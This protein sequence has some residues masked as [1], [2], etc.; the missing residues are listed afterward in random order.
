[1][2]SL[3]TFISFFKHI[4]LRLVERAGAKFNK[5]SKDYRE[6]IMNDLRKMKLSQFYKLVMLFII[7]VYNCYFLIILY[8]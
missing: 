2:I 5:N 4:V 6:M 1:M 3:V 7:F 8:C